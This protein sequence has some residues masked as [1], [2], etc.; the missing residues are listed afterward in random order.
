MGYQNSLGCQKSSKVATDPGADICVAIFFGS[1]KYFNSKNRQNSLLKQRKADYLKKE[2]N[3]KGKLLCFR[4][5]R[6]ALARN[7]AC[8]VELGR[9]W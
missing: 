9:H 1:H 8:Q 2:F 7:F 4:E 3:Y 6:L 5:T